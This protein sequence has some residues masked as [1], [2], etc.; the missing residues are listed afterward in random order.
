MEEQ[1]RA[2]SEAYH[3]DIIDISTCDG[4]G[5]FGDRHKSTA[6]ETPQADQTP[7]ANACEETSASHHSSPDENG[8]SENPFRGSPSPTGSHVVPRATICGLQP[9]EMSGHSGTATHLCVITPQRR[10]GSTT[11]HGVLLP[12]LSFLWSESLS[13]PLFKGE[14]EFKTWF[15]LPY[16]DNITDALCVEKGLTEVVST[17]SSERSGDGTCECRQDDRVHSEISGSSES[18]DNSTVCTTESGTEGLETPEHSDFGST[19]TTLDSSL[20]PYDDHLGL[21]FVRPKWRCG[22]DSSPLRDVV[23]DPKNY[24]DEETS[25]GIIYKGIQTCTPSSGEVH[26]TIKCEDVKISPPFVECKAPLDCITSNRINYSRFL[27]LQPHLKPVLAPLM[28]DS[29][30]MDL[31]EAAPL[32]KHRRTSLSVEN[33]AQLKKWDI[34]RERLPGE[35]VFP[36]RYFTVPKKNGLSRLIG[37][38]RPINQVQRPPPRMNIGD[39]RDI[40]M[41]LTKYKV[42]ATIDAVSYFYQFSFESGHHMGMAVNKGRG[43]PILLVPTVPPMGWKHM[44]YIGQ[45][46]ALAVCAEVHARLPSMDFLLVPWL[47]NFIFAAL[48]TDA[49]NTILETFRT[50]CAEIQLE[51][52]ATEH[53]PDFRSLQMLGVCYDFVTQRLQ[54]DSKWINSTARRLESASESMTFQ[55]LAELVGKFIWGCFVFGVPLSLTPNTIAAIKNTALKIRSGKLWS[56]TSSIPTHDLLLELRTLFT[57]LSTPQEVLKTPDRVDAVVTYSDGFADLSY[58]SWAFSSG[59][60]VISATIAQVDIFFAELFAATNALLHFAAQGHKAVHLLIDNSSVVFA[61]HNGHSSNSAADSII[62]HTLSQ[63]P[64]DFIYS[65]RHVH[66]EWNEADVYTR[67]KVGTNMRGPALVA[68]FWGWG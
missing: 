60:T 43:S 53:S 15:T 56:D 25:K 30:F 58:A 52:H 3:V 2:P 18:G 68:G 29:A 22:W 16:D 59:D 47:D 6:T 19:I 49:L 10:E 64:K 63:L 50:V 44:P 24:E 54:L 35:Q 45:E 39:I 48:D 38:A 9:T 28:H 62:R 5:T 66:S 14:T 4:T 23:F 37:D 57:Y 41:N 20:P 42:G 11:G 33:E 40:V 65:I 46:C 26:F 13:A 27:A 12:K 36:I 61:L 67:A 1:E 34:V 31:F 17:L 8:Y 21:N 7:N 55:A 32:K 51:L